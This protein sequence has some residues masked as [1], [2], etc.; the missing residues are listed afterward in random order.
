MTAAEPMA[1]ALAPVTKSD[2]LGLTVEQRYS[3]VSQRF[4]PCC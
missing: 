4:P 1:E 2:Y 3:V